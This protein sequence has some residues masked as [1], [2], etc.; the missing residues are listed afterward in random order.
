MIDVADNMTRLTLDTI[1]LCAFDYRF[2]SFYQREM[3]PFVERDGARAGRG[4]QPRQPRAAADASLM[5]LTHAPA[6]RPTCG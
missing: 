1:A 6:T 3:H 2:N 4:R 5:L